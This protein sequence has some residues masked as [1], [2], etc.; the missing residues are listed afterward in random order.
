MRA[1]RTNPWVRFATRRLVSL[2]AGVLILV[3]GSFM[4]VQLI[5]G[6]PVRRIAGTNVSQRYLDSVREQLGLDRSVPEQFGAYVTGV[7]VFDLGESFRTDEPVSRLIADRLPKTVELAGAALL[8]VL[9][10]GIPLGLAMGVLTRGGRHPAMG[11]LYLVGS[12]MVAAVPEFVFGTFLVYVLAVQAGVLPVAGSE[13]F[14]SLVLPA[15]AIALPAL[16]ILSRIVRVQTHDVLRQD[17]IRTARS[18][19]LPARVV[20]VRHT[21]P[22]VLT[23]ALTIGG[24]LFMGLLG[25][26]VVIENIF[27]WPG[28][29]TATVDAIEDRD[30][31]VIQG[32]ILILGVLVLVVNTLLQVVLALLDP[33]SSLRDG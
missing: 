9:L 24:L 25:G 8:V 26:T 7:A 30:Y 12:S 27:S 23:A 16:A 4:I 2:V 14:S 6:D 17:Y 5:P 22:N 28:L 11:G 33:R 32:A 21:L 3:V 20:Y 15:L 1:V 31:P 19:R 13:G 29:G 10:V 18:K